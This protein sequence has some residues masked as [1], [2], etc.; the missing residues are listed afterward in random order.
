MADPGDAGAPCAVE[1][2]GLT[3]RPDGGRPV[4]RDVDLSVAAG[5]RVLLAGPSGAG[6]STLLTVLAGLAEE[7]FDDED[8]VTGRVLL[9]GRPAAP[10]RAGLLLQDPRD[11]VVAPTAG[12]DTAFGPENLGLPREQVWARVAAAHA[13]AAFP[14][15]PDRSTAALS[16]GELQRLAVA[17]ALALRPGLLLLD[18]PTS[19]LDPATAE[20]VRDALL[21]AAGG[22]TLVVVDHDL[23]AWAAHVDRVVALGADG[24]V[25]ADGPPARVLPALAGSGLWVPGAGVPEPLAVPADLVVPALGALPGDDPALSC[26]GLRVDRRRRGPTGTTTAT[27]LRDL[28]ADLPPAALTAVTG[29]SGAGKSTLVSVLAGLVRPTAGTVRSTAALAA[30]GR[31]EPHRWSSRDL[32]R[33]VGRVPQHPP[34]GFV[35]HTVAEEARATARAVGRGTDRADALLELLGLSARADVD[36][37]RLSGGEQRRLALASA[38]AAGPSALLADEP[39]VGQDRG[40]WAAVA[41]LLTAAAAAGAAVGVATHDERLAQLAGGRVHVGPAAP[42]VAR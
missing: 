23:G 21:E 3:V 16:G 37:H 11:A 5:E 33:R 40:T 34:V 10:G 7:E 18:E 32:A 35:R 25:A 27:V 22:R 6:K 13:A 39:T 38:L 28:D 12:R 9:D 15:G 19:M 26:R 24:R 36:P 31:R 17:G 4:L 14:A 20:R 1:V 29:P 2:S 30:R 8:A 42:V 41:G